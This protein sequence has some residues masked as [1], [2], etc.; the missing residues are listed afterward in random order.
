MSGKSI[1]QTRKEFEA[2]FTKGY[3][4]SGL[5]RYSNG[6]YRNNFVDG[7]FSGWQAAKEHYAS[8]EKELE[9]KAKTVHLVWANKQ[10]EASEL[11]GAFECDEDANAY[12]LWIEQRN[13]N[14]P[15]ACDYED[16]NVWLDAV[17]AWRKEDPESETYEFCNDISVG[18]LEVSPK[19]LIAT[20][21]PQ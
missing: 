5:Q 19:A 15:E 14:R 6:R 12:K 20:K 4:G 17:E 10:W 18:P 11:M 21:E 7:A 13:S 8:R 3:Q 2:D 16:D 1:E 9:A